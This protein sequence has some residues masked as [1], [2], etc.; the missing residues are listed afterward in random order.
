MEEGEEEVEEEAEEDGLGYL[1]LWLLDLLGGVTPL[2]QVGLSAPVMDTNIQSDCQWAVPQCECVCVY[3]HCARVCCWLRGGGWGW[4]SRGNCPG[5]LA[6][7]RSSS[8]P[9]C[10]C[11]SPSPQTDDICEA[12]RRVTAG[13]CRSPPTLHQLTSTWRAGSGCVLTGPGKP[14]EWPLWLLP[15]V[16]PEP[17]SVFL[18]D[19]DKHAFTNKPQG[20]LSLRHLYLLCLFFIELWSSWIMVSVA[21]A[22]AVAVAQYPWCTK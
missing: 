22:K 10:P 18:S 12:T 20:N 3:L 8:R 17:A 6:S 14:A 7:V 11:R 16:L 19:T 2:L 1:T 4:G 15:P 21:L 13:S 5:T 9:R